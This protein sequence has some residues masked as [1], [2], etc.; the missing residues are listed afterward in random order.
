MRGLGF[1]LLLTAFAL[2]V[3][4]CAAKP[5]E[6]SL[7]APSAVEDYPP[8][9]KARAGCDRGDARSCLWIATMYRF[10]V[11]V[12]WSAANVQHGLREAERACALGFVEGC[13]DVGVAYVEPWGVARDFDRA[14]TILDDACAR[15]FAPSC[16]LLAALSAQRLVAESRAASVFRVLDADC[17]APSRRPR[18]VWQVVGSGIGSAPSSCEIVARMLEAGHGTEID[19]VR[20][21][22]LFARVSGPQEV[23]ERALSIDGEACGLG[24]RGSLEGSSSCIDGVCVADLRT[25]ARCDDPKRACTRGTF[26]GAARTCEPTKAHGAPCASGHECASDHCANRVCSE[27]PMYLD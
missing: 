19:L 3:V 24:C 15:G 18:F 14:R 25:G 16:E 20:A 11:Q 1:F 2:V 6:C 9:V 4:G 7:P 5:L 27:P 21:R 13:H 26:C 23:R 17:E 12:P 10:G 22:R 8:Y